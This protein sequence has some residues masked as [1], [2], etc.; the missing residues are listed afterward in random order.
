MGGRSSTFDISE[1]EVDLDAVFLAIERRLYIDI[2][3]GRSTA[4]NMNLLSAHF[5]EPQDRNSVVKSANFY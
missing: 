4:A 1:L 2:A 5:S 3:C